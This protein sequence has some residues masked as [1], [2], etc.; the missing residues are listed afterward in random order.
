MTNL[1]ICGTDL[2]AFEGNQPF[3]H[4]PRIL[5]HE[6]SAIVEDRNGANGFENGE[7]VTIMP[8]FYCGQCIACRKGKTNCCVDLKVFGVHIDGSMKEYISVPAY[9]I[10]KSSGLT[11]EELALVEPFAIGAHGIRRAGI[12]A[13]DTVLVIGAG[14]I[15]LGT[16][17]M[18][19]L[20]GAR[21]ISM[22]ISADR[23]N[24]AA[25]LARADEIID[26]TSQNVMEKLMELTNGNMPD[27]IIDATGNRNAINQGF[28]YICHGGKYVLIGLQ[29]EEIV[30][31][32]PEFHKREATLM[33]SRNATRQD[34]EEVIKAIK[35]KRIDVTSLI[36]HRV[37]FKEV[38][39]K[40]SS[41][42]N[43]SNHV[44]K[45]MVNFE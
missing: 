12:S 28:S 5:G 17:M 23:L 40:F 36:T 38:S 16:I 11:G 9:T 14:P 6:L 19:K 2:H 27:V 26:P 25:K 7:Q 35:D 20:T 41:W 33:S 44:I 31:S 15:G 43:P 37:P 42:L 3:F 1:G 30:M 24:I 22:D 18:A 32:H 4:Y 39:E 13:E 10:I 34:F 8:Y 45:A 29:K 21:V